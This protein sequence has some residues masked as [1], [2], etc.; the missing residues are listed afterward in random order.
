MAGNAGQQALN[1]APLHLHRPLDQPFP[2]WR[3]QLVVLGSKCAGAVLLAIGCRVRV[4]GWD[5]VAKGRAAGA[6]RQIWPK[7]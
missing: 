4:T 3:R 1:P 5:N 6:V 7:A 2:P